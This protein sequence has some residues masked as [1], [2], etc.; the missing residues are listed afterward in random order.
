MMM[1]VLLYLLLFLAIKSSVVTHAQIIEIQQQCS[2]G[3]Q[4]MNSAF[5]GEGLLITAFD[6]T[7][8]W[9]YDIDRQTRY[10]LPDTSPC[11]GNCHLSPDARWLTYYN[12]ETDSIGKMR[13]NG[14]ERTFIARNVAEVEWW[15]N[16]HVLVWTTVYEAYLQDL[17]NPLN[18][19]NLPTQSTIS[20]QPDG[21]WA[22]ALE[23]FEDT[24][25]KVILQL[26]IETSS[27][28]FL[29]SDTA[30]FN[31]GHWSPD[32][33]W[34]AYLSRG[35]FD[36]ASGIAGA[37]VFAIQPG[38]AIPQQWTFL[39]SNYGAVRIQGH[40]VDG[41]SW[42]PN[43]QY[44]AFWVTE[45]LGSDVENDLGQ[46]VI[47]LLDIQSGQL[48]AFC[49]FATNEHTPNPPR[50]IWSP[51]S[52]M[53]AFGGNIPGDDKGYLLLALDI[54]TGFITELSNGIF[55]VYGSPDVIAW[56]YAP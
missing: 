4:P 48:T 54:Q 10:P 45:L 9:V 34:Y 43:S 47:H 51:D 8:M 55:P 21:D 41:L 38:S 6:S 56:G 15:S 13:L 36:E 50:L 24:F 14:T 40:A 19:L 33:S 16:N 44:L 35:A 12:A 5:T 2:A 7:S 49:G 30:F 17:D 39:T 18:I 1:R 29:S 27:S 11:T 53:I 28:T 42:S 37:E 26:G 3:I 31:A 20:I 25:Y 46:A 32:G 22:I 52:K 23:Q